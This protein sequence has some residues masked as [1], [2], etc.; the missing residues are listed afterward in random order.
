MGFATCDYLTEIQTIIIFPAK[1]FGSKILVLAYAVD[2]FMH[3]LK[4]QS[5]TRTFIFNRHITCG[6]GTI[7]NLDVKHPIISD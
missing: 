7:G 4:I 1:K 6:L 5:Q 2:P 3:L